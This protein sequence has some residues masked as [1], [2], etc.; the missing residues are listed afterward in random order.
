M[1]HIYN[2]YIFIFL[3]VLIF[4]NRYSCTAENPVS[5]QTTQ[6]FCFLFFWM[7]FRSNMFVVPFRGLVEL[8]MLC[9]GADSLRWGR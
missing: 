4:L 2:V 1:F 9:S 3:P 5:G 8:T 7:A 6:V